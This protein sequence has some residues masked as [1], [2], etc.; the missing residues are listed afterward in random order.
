MVL[1]LAVPVLLLSCI[2]AS[3]APRDPAWVD[4]RVA[5]WQP[6]DSERAWERMETLE[7]VARVALAARSLGREQELPGPDV[8]RLES[9]RTAAGYP[10]PV[11]VDCPSCGTSVAVGSGDQVVLT[12]AEL[13][14]LL[15]EAVER[16][17]G[18]RS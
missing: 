11:C 7:Q 16:F 14:R 6:T 15:A 12:R 17:G 10:P 2:A 1:R 9:A 8:R 4:E 5:R 18:A 13:A 3:A